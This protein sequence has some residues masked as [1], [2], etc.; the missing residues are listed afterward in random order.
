MYT[1][2]GKP[3][4]SPRDRITPRCSR[5]QQSPQLK[6]CWG[7]GVG[8]GNMITFIDRN[9]LA[10][11]PFIWVGWGGVGQYKNVHW[12]EL[13]A[14]ESLNVNKR[15]A[16]SPYA[17]RPVI[18]SV[19]SAWHTNRPHATSWNACGLTP[20][21][22]VWISM[23]TSDRHL[24]QCSTLIQI[25]LAALKMHRQKCMGLVAPTKA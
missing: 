5:L 13:P 18:Y 16:K 2:R 8:W 12:Q 10:R 4:I 19:L 21:K 1:Y 3:Q 20:R 24:L 22:S 17:F 6:L 9:F 14:P 15:L 25:V 23:N 7:G 11:N